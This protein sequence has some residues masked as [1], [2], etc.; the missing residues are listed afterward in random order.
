LAITGFD[1]KTLT[2][3][4][5]NL[6][7]CN[8]VWQLPDGIGKPASTFAFEASF[9]ILLHLLRRLRTQ[10]AVDSLLQD[11]SRWQGLHQH[12]PQPVGRS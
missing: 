9:G 2:I 1:A 8:G 12:F 10:N 3:H 4:F 11:G 7:W 6:M 5:K